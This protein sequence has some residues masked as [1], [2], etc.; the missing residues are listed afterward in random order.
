M[1]ATQFP[2]EA[3]AAVSG[4]TSIAVL[5]ALDFHPSAVAG[6][7]L[8]LGIGEPGAAVWGLITGTLADQ[9]D[10]QDALD[11]KAGASAVA[12]SFSAVDDALA[13]KA[14]LDSPAFTNNPTATTQSAGNSSTRLATTEFVATAVANLIASAPG[15]LDTLD[16]LAAALGDDANF[17]S[18]ITT[19]V[20]GKLAKASNLSDLTDASAARTN[21]G[22]GTVATHAASEFQTALGS[23]NGLVKG[24]GAGAYS[25]ATAGTDYAGMSVL[26]AF[27]AKATWTLNS[28]TGAVVAISAGATGLRG[29]QVSKTSADGTVPIFE[30]INNTA[31]TVF[32]VFIDHIEAGG[33]NIKSVADPVDA[34]DAATKAYVD[35][36]GGGGGSISDPHVYYVRSDGNDST[37]DGSAGA[38][39]L[40]G[41][42]AYTEGIAGAVPFA[43]DFGIGSFSITLAADWNALCRIV[44]G[45]GADAR[46]T[47]PTFSHVQINAGGGFASNT[48]G[49][50]G[51]D[52]AVTLDAIQVT[53]STVGGF[54]TADDAGSY[55]G[56]A[57]GA[58][59]LRGRGVIA[60]IDARGGGDSSSSDGSVTGGN[61]ASVTIAGSFTTW[62]TA[63]I[64]NRGG[65]EYNGGGNGA[66]GTLTADGCDF[67]GATEVAVGDAT[68]GR[69]SYDVALST[70]GT[71]T[72]K[73]GNANWT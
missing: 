7:L 5:D 14:P 23:I 30:A 48:N 67:R 72:D 68:F 59:E 16:E 37:G 66:D 6:T 27:T 57:G 53:I 45:A 71:F 46:A 21:L 33:T 26:N 25:A 39:W 63:G 20:G 18:T 22:L 15:A 28:G 36:S 13:L 58:V 34:Q 52:V 73:G 4:K 12:A 3:L 1:P 2:V 55:T 64:S 69:C 11:A 24:N 35:A 54:V 43:I 50:D 42:K 70:T 60:A 41:G 32:S 9:T 61:G 29:L 17:A 40:T 31:G 47:G 49:E 8:S 10:L 56:G 44:R 51:Y 19:A 62:P 65:I 38:P